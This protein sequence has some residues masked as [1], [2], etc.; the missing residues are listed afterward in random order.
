MKWLAWLSAFVALVSMGFAIHAATGFLTAWVTTEQ[1]HR[2]ILIASLLAITP[3]IVWMCLA[4]RWHLIDAT[5]VAPSDWTSVPM[6]TVFIGIG[7]TMLI[8]QFVVMRL[9][10][11]GELGPTPVAMMV[12][13]ML[14]WLLGML[15]SIVVLALGWRGS[16]R[17]V[18][19]LGLATSL[20]TAIGLIKACLDFSSYVAVV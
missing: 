7:W 6:E 8:G 2:S 14:I 18:R 1:G 16:P 20:L 17:P 11:R 4:W 9:A 3:T 5:K 15:T 13:P 12:L 10:A 19:R